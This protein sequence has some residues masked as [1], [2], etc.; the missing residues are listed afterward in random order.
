MGNAKGQ[1]RKPKPTHLK[2]LEGDPNKCR[3]NMD[4][5]K[6]YPKAPKVPTW[7]SREAKAEWRRLAP[8]LEAIGILT[9]LDMAMF[10]SYCAAFGKLVWAEKMIKQ[11]RK[12]GAKLSGGLIMQTPTGAYQTNPYVW[13]YN[14]ALEQIR[15]FGS[16]FGLS[17]SSRTRIKVVKP[18]T[19]ENTIFTE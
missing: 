11:Q 9:E 13:I 14:K 8:Q 10:A 12:E 16:E 2:L 6:P 15:N 3:I 4:E 18:D 19:D 1:G 5:P 17:P 7:L